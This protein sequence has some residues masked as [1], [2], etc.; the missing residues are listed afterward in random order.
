MGYYT[1]KLNVKSTRLKMIAFVEA[2]LVAAITTH[3]IVAF[4]NTMSN[5]KQ[6]DSELSWKIVPSARLLLLGNKNYIVLRS[7]LNVQIINIQIV[8]GVFG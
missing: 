5:V 6:S 7:V 2:V 3:F 1:N 4:D 8:G